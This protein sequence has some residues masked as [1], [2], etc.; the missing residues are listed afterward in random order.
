MLT[1]FSISKEKKYSLLILDLNINK[2]KAGEDI[3]YT[4]KKSYL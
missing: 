3:V 4:E 1:T 2:I